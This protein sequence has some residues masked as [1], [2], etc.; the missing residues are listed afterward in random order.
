M[1]P[2]RIAV[3]GCGLTGAAAAIALLDRVAAPFELFIVEPDARL[4]HGLAYGRAEPHQVLNARAGKMSIRC[5]QPGDFVDWLDAHGAGLDWT[6]VLLPD[7][8]SAF[9]P[10][11]LFGAYVEAQLMEA[12][13]RRYDLRTTH[14]QTEAL[15]LQPSAQGFRIV[16]ERH[17]PIV[18]DTVMLAIGYGRPRNRTNLGRAAFA[19]IDP[20][21][22]R[23]ARSALFVG[24]GLTFVDEF[25]RLHGMGFRGAAR[26][27]SP[28]GLLPEPYGETD[29][30]PRP[31]LLPDGAGLAEMLR[32]FRRDVRAAGPGASAADFVAGLRGEAQLLWRSLGPARQASFLRHLK[33]YWDTVRHRLP[34]GPHALVTLARQAGVLAVE[35][36][37]VLATRETAD[38]DQAWL[39]RRGSPALVKEK[40]DLVFDCSGSRAD[41]ANPLVRALIRQ[42][43]AFAAPQGAGLAV[44]PNGSLL[45]R[46][47]RT[48]GEL[49]ALGPLGH[50]S[51]YEI[52]AAREIVA[53]CAAAA[54]QVNEAA[55][56]DGPA[57]AITR[58]LASAGTRWQ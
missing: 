44:A 56:R 17:G 2:R 9:L 10:R 20:D 23:R 21:K 4:G 51:L 37:R 13:A 11:K 35:R 55:T 18:V 7:P 22:V 39:R 15:D 43:R 33:P 48:S 49:F 50:G 28:R 3:I 19:P 38:G 27:V 42:G 14:L 25:I 24:T 29:T 40:F 6:H 34:P 8:G 57:P 5:D 47:G 58:R 53:Q 46:F 16:L 36:G 45:D 30:G 1:P 41:T 31:A 26:A 52:T 12:I 54:N 32:V